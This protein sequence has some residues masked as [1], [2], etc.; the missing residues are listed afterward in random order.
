MK[1]HEAV[2]VTQSAQEIAIVFEQGGR[3]TTTSRNV[4]EAFEKRHNDVLRDIRAVMRDTGEDFNLRNFAQIDYTDAKGRAYPEYLI[5]KDGFTLLV[6]GYTGAKAMQFKVAYI[7]AFNKME[8][9]LQERAALPT[10]TATMEAKL[11]VLISLLARQNAPQSL[12]PASAWH[13]TPQ[14]RP[15]RRRSRLTRLC[16]LLCAPWTTRLHS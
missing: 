10:G 12:Q 11:D 14:N 16:C 2:T 3:P 1:E 5:T 6:M 15:K 7:N 13:N 4:A 9:A 8:A